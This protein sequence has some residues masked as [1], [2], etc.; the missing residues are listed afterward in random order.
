MA[1]KNSQTLAWTMSPSSGHILYFPSAVTEKTQRS[2]KPIKMEGGGKVKT[3]DETMQGGA[4]RQKKPVHSG[5]IS[6]A[7][8]FSC[9]KKIYN[10]KKIPTF[11]LCT[12]A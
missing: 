8:V 10:N 5:E 11:N 12:L 1:K 4:D 7:E 2:A 3:E 6:V 9:L